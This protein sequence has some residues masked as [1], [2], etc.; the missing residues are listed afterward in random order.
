MSDYGK[1]LR[2]DTLRI[3]RLL[4]GP[5]ER[6]WAYL[7]ES[8]KRRKWLA[9]G[10][11]EPPVG[12]IM[13]MHILHSELS[14]EKT[15]PERFKSIENG[16]S[17]HERITRYEPPHILG[18]TW[19]GDQPGAVSEVI[20]ELTEQGDQVLLVLTHSRLHD[21][22]DTVGSASGWY[23]HLAMLEDVLNGRE[24][25]PFWTTHARAEAEYERLIPQ[26]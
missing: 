24:T 10:E 14:A 2:P 7:T 5:I 1:M 8:E 15:A 6:V 22:A 25:R 3:E 4:P 21:R 18:L 20:F 17:G 13:E 12:G 23:A 11:M 9:R 19:G 16:V 26:G